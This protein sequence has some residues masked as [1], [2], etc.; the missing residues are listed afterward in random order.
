ML[1]CLLLVILLSHFENCCFDFYHYRLVL[2]V[3]ELHKVN[4]IACILLCLA[5][6]GQHNVRFTKL[7]YALIFFFIAE[8]YSIVFVYH[9]LLVHS[10]YDRH[11]GYFQ[12]RA[13]T[14]KATMN[15]PVQIFLWTCISFPLESIPRDRM[16]RLCQR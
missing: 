9:I 2:S 7:F 3:P 15:T 1:L 16:T 8:Q 10:P 5:S 11:L 4:P 12:F 6:F 14:S 13:I